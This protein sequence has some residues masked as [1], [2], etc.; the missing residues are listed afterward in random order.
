MGNSTGSAVRR[1]Q[2]LG[3]AWA[4]PALKGRSVRKIHGGKEACPPAAKPGPSHT[5]DAI[6]G[7][8]PS[9]ERRSRKRVRQEG[10]SAAKRKRIKSSAQA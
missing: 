1:M 7:L 10:D 5:A 9:L 3:R 6:M 2:A 4:L 8:S